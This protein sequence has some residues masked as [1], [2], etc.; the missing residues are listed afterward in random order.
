MPYFNP[1]ET[2]VNLRGNLP[3]WRQR[4]VMYF[5]TF[6]TRDSIPQGR[7]QEW[8]REH[9]AWLARH[10]GPH[11][12]EER[13]TYNRLFPRRFLRWLDDGHGKCVLRDVRLRRVVEEALQHFDGRRY[14]L[15]EYAI[16]PNHVHIVV[17]PTSHGLSS[18]LGSWKSYT[19]RE[20]NRRL[21][22]SGRFWQKESFDHIVRSRD[23][24]ERVRRYIREQ[25]PE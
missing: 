7:L 3:H 23:E 24:L 13:R 6:R 16:L 9:Q 10:P 15:D 14:E 25:R 12:R 2:I 20:I 8:R 22:T 5:V 11:S 1:G 19:A 17:K 21:G 4:G 18:I